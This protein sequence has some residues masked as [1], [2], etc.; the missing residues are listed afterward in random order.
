MAATAD[1]AYIAAWVDRPFAERFA[2]LAAQNERSA[3]AEA[4]LAL[5]RHLE[6][7]GIEVLPAATGTKPAG[8][9]GPAGTGAIAVVHK[10]EAAGAA[11]GFRTPTAAA[12]AKGP[13]CTNLSVT[14]P[15]A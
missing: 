5:R 4:R 11:V 14:K 13:K 6:S 8:T 1:R 2:A 15:N 7:T 9:A 3:S 10:H 12:S